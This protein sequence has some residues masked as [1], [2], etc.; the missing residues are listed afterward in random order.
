MP[1]CH[2]CYQSKIAKG[3]WVTRGITVTITVNPILYLL[4][5]YRKQCK[6]Y[7]Y[8]CLSDVFQFHKSFQ[9]IQ[10]SPNSPCCS[11]R[12][13][14]FIRWQKM[15]S[16]RITIYFIAKLLVKSIMFLVQLW[17]H[18]VYKLS[19]PFKQITPEIFDYSGLP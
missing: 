1:R 3:L 6:L 14:F 2:P 11:T 12:S 9:Y 7:C 19:L 18:R 13:Q 17:L 10:L 15:Q 5:M 8:S 16:V 4:Y